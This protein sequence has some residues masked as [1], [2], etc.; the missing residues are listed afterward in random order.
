MGLSNDPSWG[1]YDMAVGEKITSV[2]AGA[3]DSEQFFSDLEE[4]E[5]QRLVKEELTK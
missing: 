1:S 3:A 4:A 2:F 5:Q